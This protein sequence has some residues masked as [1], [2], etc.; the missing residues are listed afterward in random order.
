[1]NIIL[2]VWVSTARFDKKTNKWKLTY[3]N[4]ITGVENNIEVDILV[5]GVGGLRIPNIPQDLT[6]FD[7]PWMHSAKWDHSIDLVGKKVGIIG[8][9]ASAVQIVP[10]IINK[11]KELHTFQRTP[12][13]VLPR[14]MYK[15]S[16]LFKALLR[17][18][19]GLL[20][21]YY[22]LLFLFADSQLI[23]FYT[24]SWAAKIPTFFTK[25]YIN[26]VINDP[27]KRELMIP[28]YHFGCK[29]ITPSDTYYQA[30]NKRN[31]H[32]HDGN[33][34][35]I[36]GKT[37]Y[38]KDGTKQ[39]VDVLILATGFKVASPY[40]DF[41]IIDSS[42]EHIDSKHERI[43][44]HPLLNYG[45]TKANMP[46]FFMMLGPTTGL[47]HNT[48]TWMIECQGNYICDMI[49][50]MMKYDVARFELKPEVGESYWQWIQ[51]RVRPMVWYG[52][53]KSW[54]QNVNGEVLAIW[55]GT[56]TE[57]YWRTKSA[58]LHDYDC[59]GKY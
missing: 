2:N 33:I 43:G 49:G 27:R 11:V 26:S 58:S 23:A 55:P 18:V 53:C 57:Y 45:I 17:Y 39:T 48:I 4:K 1:N 59:Y 5:G 34:A 29:R 19:P 25:K 50:K 37:L 13:Y 52:N 22:W 31:V 7:G 38:L 32:I 3:K 14:N 24:G 30:I 51:R 9:G 54:Y 41:D 15:Y 6:K 12:P 10:N 44:E 47:G 21:A 35:K 20:K 16:S 42:N 40:K 56:C 8:S 28:K 46:N 36:E